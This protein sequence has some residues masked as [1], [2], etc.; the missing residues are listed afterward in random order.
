MEP[1]VE[2]SGIPSAFQDFVD[3]ELSQ[4]SGFWLDLPERGGEENRLLTML[5]YEAFSLIIPSKVM[6]PR[7][8]SIK[9][10][11]HKL[12][13]ISREGSRLPKSCF[14]DASTMVALDLLE[15]GFLQNRDRHDMDPTVDSI[16][17]NTTFRVKSTRGARARA[18]EYLAFLGELAQIDKDQIKYH[19]R[20]ARDLRK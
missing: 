8:W 14:M 2:R 9:S 4:R 18:Y 6:D 3:W 16:F 19:R 13:R 17:K 12:K 10:I 15:G 1:M 7:S 11:S 5:A 20:M